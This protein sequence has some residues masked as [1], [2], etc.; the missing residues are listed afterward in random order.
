MGGNNITIEELLK[1]LPGGQIELI[2]IR[3]P[4]EHGVI[5]IKNAKLIPMREL[6]HRLSEIDWSKTVV[7]F[8]RTGSRSS[9]IVRKLGEA[10]KTTLD[11]AGGIK[12]CY[13]T[14]DFPGLVIGGNEQVEQYLA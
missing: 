9:H 10:G 12:A 4:E 11:L 1:L 13:E 7:I 2:D 14:K 6:P 8:C 5:H 3:E